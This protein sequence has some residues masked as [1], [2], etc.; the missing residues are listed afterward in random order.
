MIKGPAKSTRTRTRGISSADC[1]PPPPIG[2]GFRSLEAVSE[3]PRGSDDAFLGADTR[4]M[5][6]VRNSPNSLLGNLCKDAL[7]TGDAE[8]AFS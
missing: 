2:T 5:P 4:R 1:G 7:C 6:W 8:V 3:S